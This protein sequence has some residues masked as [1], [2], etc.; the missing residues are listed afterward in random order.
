M[1]K[2]KELVPI[3]GRPVGPRI[4]T[5]GTAIVTP[6][7]RPGPAG[8][9]PRDDSHGTMVVQ[10]PELD[11]GKLLAA[12]PGLSHQLAQ[13]LASGRFLVTVHW[14]VKDT[15]PDDLMHGQT[16]SHSF[17]VE[18]MHHCLDEV[19]KLLPTAPAG[20]TPGAESWR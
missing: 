8:P 19:K 15:P 1:E 9:R 5:P 2:E 13:A 18:E 16:H 12:E 11:L 4:V 20:E 7:A 3:G 14:K 17:P 10:I 6:G